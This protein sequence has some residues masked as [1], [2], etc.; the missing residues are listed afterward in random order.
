M[1]PCPNNRDHSKKDDTAS[2]CL[3]PSVQA[4]P[5]YFGKSCNSNWQRGNWQCFPESFFSLKH[6]CL[7]WAFSAFLSRNLV[8]HACLSLTLKA[9]QNLEIKWVI[10][11]SSVGQTNH[12]RQCC[13]KELRMFNRKLQVYFSRECNRKGCIA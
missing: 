4:Q 6:Q 7:L 9:S 5:D 3:D 12:L 11:H 8:V 10:P 2:S 1:R 13:A